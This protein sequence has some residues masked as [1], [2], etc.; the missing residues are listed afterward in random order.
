V[1]DLLENG[2][3]VVGYPFDGYWRDLGNSGDYEEAMR[4]FQTMRDQFLPEGR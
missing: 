4:D 1:L 2:E 3:S